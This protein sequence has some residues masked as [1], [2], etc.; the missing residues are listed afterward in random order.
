MTLR[1]L[2]GA[3]CA[4]AAALSAASSADV[5]SAIRNNNLAALDS[6]TKD[7]ASVNLKDDRGI[8]P[9]M[10]AAVAG[11]RDAMKLLIER[12]AEVNAKNAFGST[13]LMWSATDLEKTRLL[14][15]AHADPNLVSDTGRTALLIAA[16]SD[17]SAPI[18]RLLISKGADIHVVDRAGFTA[19]N[20]AAVGG[21]FETV[22]ILLDA[23]LDVSQG[24]AI[25]ITPLI[26]S[27][28][29]G[30]WAGMK[31][32]IAK[33]ADVNKISGN[34][35]EKVKH[36]NIEL[37]YA[38][39]LM[40]AVTERNADAVKA[41]LDAGADANLKDIRGM[42]ALMLAVATDHETL[43]IVTMVLAKTSDRKAADK[44]QQTALDWA[45]KGGN[46]QVIELLRSAGVPDSHLKPVEAPPAD[47]VD[48]RPAVERSVALLERNSG[49]FFVE[50][51]CASC[52]AENMAE[53]AVSV[54]RTRGIRIDERGVAD[55]QR[56]NRAEFQAAGPSLLERQDTPGSPDLPLYAL[57]AMA[58]AHQP[59]DRMTDSMLSNVA[60]Q[61]MHDGNWHLGGLPRP[62]IEDGDTFR[63]A[64]AIRA[65]SAYG[66]PGRAAEWKERI[67][68]GK[69]WLAS[70][71]PATAEDRN[72]QLLGL[73]WAGDKSLASAAKG[74]LNFQ[75]PD[76]GWA[77]RTGLASDAYATG[78]SLYALAQSG[79]ISP[80]DPDYQR[81]V[82]YLL[83]EQ[84]A[85]GS[86]HVAS[87]SP[88]FQPYFESGF[89]Y[90]HDQ[91]ISSMATG[92][93]TA[94]LAFALEPVKLKAGE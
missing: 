29:S 28:F 76:G 54:A 34:F 41:L 90:H 27:I 80:D 25:G 20:A 81:G 91:W 24:M 33:G 78:Q 77:Q 73:Y 79:A 17:R 69:S 86:W 30:D 11:S 46:R 67:A 22:K 87:R 18:V 36:G 3:L 47:P 70:S 56:M 58:A 42:N 93:A 72:Y 92:W 59:A 43:E 14:L 74:I 15:E 71:K 94:A 2:L 55:R 51:G 40:C 21:D 50:G 7:R 45:K 23:G 16:L 12:G 4:S 32:L 10:M 39:P 6:L 57:A 83:S 82:K 31:A 63:T 26:S 62:P 88:K 52:H 84:R 13:A 9:L 38:S 64:L 66:A 60:A 85:D 61:Q 48:L 1:N 65:L 44:Y 49:K 35:G 89:P 68:R 53:I 37:G 5:Y 8:T 75:R 19:L